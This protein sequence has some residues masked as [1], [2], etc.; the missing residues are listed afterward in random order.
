M[1]EHTEL[2]FLSQAVSLMLANICCKTLPCMLSAKVK[3]GSVEVTGFLPFRREE[4]ID[5]NLRKL[6]FAL[7]AK[8][9]RSWAQEH[10]GRTE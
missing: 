7:K 6:L 1:E 5:V 4:N 8:T 9:N 2:P 3:L 10:S